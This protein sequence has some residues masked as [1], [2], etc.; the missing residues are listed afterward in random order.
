MILLQTQTVFGG[1]CGSCVV[2]ATD[3]DNGYESNGLAMAI[4][5]VTMLMLIFDLSRALLSLP[6]NNQFSMR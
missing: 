6:A 2:A 3:Y 5:Q 1:C 4:W